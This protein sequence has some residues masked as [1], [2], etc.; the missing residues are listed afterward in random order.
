M[1]FARYRALA[2]VIALKAEF[3]AS[4]IR[5]PERLDGEGRTVGGGAFTHGHLYLILA[6]P[7]YVGHLAHRGRVHAGQH[8]GIVDAAT[9][10]AVQAQ[11]AHNHRG[12]TARRQA[13]AHIL[14]G[15]IRDDQGNTM[16]PSH[17]VKGARRYRHY[18]S[19]AVLRGEP[20]GPVR[21]IAAH[22]VEAA[23][24]AALRAADLPS[25]EPRDDAALIAER[26]ERVVEELVRVPI[27]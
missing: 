18:V 16:T 1:I 26:I 20:T 27:G 8:A 3:D 14:A 6:S 10:E 2:S 12:H 9:F 17:T 25:G 13:C 4:G 5:A 22:A 7:T 23:V 21:R 24:L 11:L 15:R 19:R